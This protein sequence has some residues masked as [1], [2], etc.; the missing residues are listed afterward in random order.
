MRV[1]LRLV[2][3]WIGCPSLGL[4]YGKFFWGNVCGQKLERE[5]RKGDAEGFPR[6]RNLQF[7]FSFSE[8]ILERTISLW[9]RVCTSDQL[10]VCCARCQ[11]LLFHCLMVFRWW[12]RSGDRQQETDSEHSEGTRLREGILVSV[13]R[14]Q[15]LPS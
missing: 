10:T 4:N 1:V 2:W 8:Q 12:V 6:K 7:S 14:I 13:N 9:H 3:N 5:T 15:V 11:E